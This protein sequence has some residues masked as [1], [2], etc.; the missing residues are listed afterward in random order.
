MNDLR[1]LLE[2]N[3]RW[4]A[5]MESRAPGFFAGLAALQSPRYLWIGCS[6][7]RVP[8]NEIVGLPPGE[9]FVHR[10]VANIVM[11]NDFSCLSVLQYAVDVLG[12]GTSSCAG[13]TAAAAC[14][15]PGSGGN[16]AWWTTGC[17]RYAISR[18]S[19]AMRWTNCPRTRS[20]STGF[21]S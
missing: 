15:R 9:L 21:A 11:H 17:A 1:D 18:C 12:V 10:N 13:T 16:S 8:A 14:R 19:T 4:A 3:R 2:N 5:G 20:G 7:S 6:D